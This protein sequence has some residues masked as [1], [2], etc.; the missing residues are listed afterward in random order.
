MQNLCSCTKAYSRAGSRLQEHTI[1]SIRSHTAGRFSYSKAPKLNIWRWAATTQRPY[2]LYIEVLEF[3]AGAEPNKPLPDDFC[4]GPAEAGIGAEL[5][6]PLTDDFCV[7]ALELETGDDPNMPPPDSFCV[8]AVESKTGE[9]PNKLPPDSLDVEVKSVEDPNKPPADGPGIAALD[10]CPRV[11]PDRLLPNPP[12]GFCVD[13]WESESVEGSW[14]PPDVLRDFAC[15]GPEARNFPSEGLACLLC[16][17]L[18][19]SGIELASRAASA[20]F[21]FELPEFPY[22]SR[23]PAAGEPPGG[24]LRLL[25]ARSVAFC[26]RLEYAI[27]NQRCCGS[28]RGQSTYMR[29]CACTSCR[30]E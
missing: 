23:L 1:Q 13:A 20:I 28:K 4:V 17:E 14:Q 22:V 18:P 29:S 15:G 3:K 27:V 7:G 30:S 5:N 11:G 25:T 2:E 9:D 24:P 6:R 8:A 12:N 16:T 10:S 21:S 26:V 19:A